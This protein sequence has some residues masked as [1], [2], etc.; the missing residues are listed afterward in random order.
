MTDDTEL[1]LVY[2]INKIIARFLYFIGILITLI[3]YLW[4]KILDLT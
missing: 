2:K 1:Q 4:I 3:I